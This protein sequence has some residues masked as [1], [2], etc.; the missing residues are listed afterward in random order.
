MGYVFQFGEVF[1]YWPLLVE[2]AIATVAASTIT[3]VLGLALGILGAVARLS[4]STVLRSIAAAY[5]ES[6]RNTPL[7]VQLF[8]IYFALPNLGIRFPPDIAALVALV[9]NNGAY[10]TEIM[11]AGIQSIHPSQTEAGLSLGLSRPQTFLYIVLIPA[12]VNV[13]PALVSQFILVMLG[14]SIVSVIG[15]EELTSYANFI[16]STN[17]RS[18][19]V[20]IVSTF[21]YLALAL[22]YRILFWLL[23]LALFPTRR[24]FFNFKLAFG[25]AT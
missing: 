19:E 21:I 13:Y 2:G 20:Y 1:R 17:F 24:S 22:A 18:F 12:L 15:A 16:Q 14:T 7:L 3:I 8:L 4:R 5:V 23:S 6:F 10:T 9:L 11:R 25:A